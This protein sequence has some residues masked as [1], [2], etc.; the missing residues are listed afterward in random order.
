MK[1]RFQSEVCDGCHD[2]LMMSI[3]Y[4]DIVILNHND[5]AILLLFVVLVVVALLIES[6]K[7]KL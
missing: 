3:N 4:N 5:I 1:F 6:A 2:V 7:V